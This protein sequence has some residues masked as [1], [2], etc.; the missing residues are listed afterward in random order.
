VDRLLHRIYTDEDLY[1]ITVFCK[2]ENIPEWKNQL[3]PAKNVHITYTNPGT[4]GAFSFVDA[5]INALKWSLREGAHRCVLLSGQCYPIQP[6]KQIRDRISSECSYIGYVGKEKFNSVVA[7]RFNY[8]Y[9]RIPNPNIF[10]IIA[11]RPINDRNIFIKYPR[12]FRKLPKNMEPYKGSNWMILKREH[13]AYVIDY[14]LDNPH[15][16][17]FF[18]RFQ[19]ADESFFHTI[20]LNS[21]YK[22]EIVNKCQTFVDWQDRGHPTPNFLTTDQLGDILSSDCLFARK[23]D[24]NIDS[25]VLD[26]I[27]K[28][29]LV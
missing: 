7:D 2:E 17:H 23:F 24:F 12:V 20:L 27:D 4:H 5:N 13:I 6:L 11:G 29:I 8:N 18:K 14:I 28:H 3:P 10:R 22:K 19:S 1:N 25:R 9:Y 21:D 16:V 26:C 15:Y